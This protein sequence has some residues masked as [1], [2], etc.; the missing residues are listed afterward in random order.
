[1]RNR[2]QAFDSPFSWYPTDALTLHNADVPRR[3]PSP[4]GVPV[5]DDRKGTYYDEANPTGRRQG[6]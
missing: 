1:M 4:K 3:C 6:H 5:F 2:I